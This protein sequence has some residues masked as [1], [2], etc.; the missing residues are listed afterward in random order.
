[1]KA[2]EFWNKSADQYD[3]NVT[4]TYGKAYRD[5]IALTTAYLSRDSKVLDFGC[6]TGLITNAIAQYVDTITAIDLSEN[7]IQNAI[8]KAHEMGVTNIQYSVSD[9][10]DKRIRAGSYNV[11]AAFNVLYFV[12]DLD[13]LLQRFYAM[14]PQ[15]GFFLSVTDCL[16]ETKSIK[17]GALKLMMKLGVLPYARFL[18]VDSLTKT[19]QNAGFC[20]VKTENLYPSPPN[21]FIAAQ[22]LS[23][24][25]G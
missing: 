1:M 19:V 14:L 10:D 24:N 11:I 8:R 22:K 2:K 12:K 7:M 13:A 20:I 3:R 5:T 6:G 23:Q 9:L 25:G 15:G 21:L 4:K 17:N 16:G 18:T